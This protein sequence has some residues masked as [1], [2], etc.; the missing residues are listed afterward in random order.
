MNKEE[1]KALDM[2]KLAKDNWVKEAKQEKAKEM[3]ND[4]MKILKYY[5]KMTTY[6]YSNDY[7]IKEL[8]K[9]HLEG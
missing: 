2:V 3:I 5:E 8:K 6:N 4:F 9:K 7:R 1:L